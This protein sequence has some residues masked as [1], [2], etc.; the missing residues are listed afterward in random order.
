MHKLV[1][2]ARRKP[3]M[4]LDH[5]R[6]DWHDTH[7]RLVTSVAGDLGLHRDVQSIRLESEAMQTSADI[8]GS[9]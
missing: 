3:G 4:T 9:T 8:R 5:G 1:I 2:L 7:A 6:D